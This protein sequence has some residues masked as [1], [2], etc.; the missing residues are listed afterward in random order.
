VPTI[1]NKTP[2]SAKM[3]ATFDSKACEKHILVV[4]A[5]FT[6]KARDA[7][8]I[9]QEQMEISPVDTYWGD[10]ANTSIRQPGQM[11]FDKPCV[12]VIV[13][14][15]AIPPNGRRIT[16][17]EIGI[18]ISD[19]SKVLLVSGDRF[20]KHGVTGKIPSS[21]NYFERIPVTFER[22]FGGGVGLIDSIATP[23]ELRNPVGVGVGGHRSIH[24]NVNTEI[25]NFEYP[26]DRQ[27]NVDQ[28]P[29]PACFGALAPGWKPRSDH[30]GTYD[31]AWL[32]EQAPLLPHDFDTRF[33]Q[34]APED[35]R[36]NSVKV[37]DLVQV[38]GMTPEGIWQFQVPHVN[39]PVTLTYSDRL[40]K[41]FLSLDCIHL[42]PDLYRVS[43][44]G[45]LVIQV[46]RNYAPL[47]HIVIGKA[48][49]AWIRARSSGKVYR[50]NKGSVL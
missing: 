45:R 14:G 17:M 10:P 39:L 31:S 16:S 49:A 9:S 29:M 43:M 32:K 37:D 26:N 22:A 4:S 7:V 36:S 12:D 11:V 33:F 42:E 50:P 5:S 30:A 27:L 13:S 19:I 34:F 1:D 25:P 35:Q 20:W 21:P 38:N 40:Q 44:I 41:A 48:S 2:F 46:R 24:P 3:F 8:S 15:H 47:E 18:K 28:R 23:Y 6:A